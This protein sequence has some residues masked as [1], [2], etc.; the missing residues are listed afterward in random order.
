[1]TLA[2]AATRAATCHHMSVTAPS[3]AELTS[4]HDRRDMTAGMEGVPQ[5]GDLEG[6][7][8]APTFAVQALAD[9]YARVLENPTCRWSTWDAIR[10]GVAPRLGLPETLR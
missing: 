10:A 6:A 1:M 5:G 3:L 7:G 2:R 8:M 9:Y 4:L